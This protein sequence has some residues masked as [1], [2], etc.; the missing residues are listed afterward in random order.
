MPK[1][2]AR[3]I[4]LL[5]S[6]KSVSSLKAFLETSGMARHIVKF[7]KQTKSSPKV[8]LPTA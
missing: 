6:K 3:T 4:K 5:P 7:R 8:T 2:R 1:A